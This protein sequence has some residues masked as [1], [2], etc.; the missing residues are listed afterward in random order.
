[1]ARD[2][3]L[4]VRQR[5]PRQNAVFRHLRQVAGYQNII[6]S[7]ACQAANAGI[8]VIFPG[9][10][11]KQR[12]ALRNF[13]VL[14][15]IFHAA[16]RILRRSFQ[17]CTPSVPVIHVR[18]PQRPD[19]LAPQQLQ[20][21]VHMVAVKMRQHQIV[22]AE[23]APALQIPR[24]RLS[25]LIRHAAAIHHRRPSAAAVHETLSLPHI[26]H[27]E[28]KLRRAIFHC[29]APEAHA[30]ADRRGRQRLPLPHRFRSQCQQDH[31][32]VE[33]DC[34]HSPICTVQIH[35]REWELCRQ[36]HHAEHI[37]R[38]PRQNPPER[39]TNTRQ[40]QSRQAQHQPAR[41]QNRHRP[42]AERIDDQR[43]K[44]HRPEMHRRQRQRKYHRRQRTAKRREHCP[45]QPPDPFVPPQKLSKPL[46]NRK[47]PVDLSGKQ[48]NARRRRE[49]EL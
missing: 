24:R 21:A 37:P 27:R 42:Q 28:R 18:E 29:R 35:R 8:V 23:H 38:Q 19:L 16:A 9:D 4:D 5:M 33:R 3:Q 25:G 47:R 44:R 46:S 14:P 6:F 17:P 43:R 2:E 48:Q 32:T 36:M 1:M 30:E 12:H 26:Q 31:Q 11:R 7:R 22:H 13:A 20:R 39:R 41:E 49:R 40:K 34:K 10:R 15:H 45:Q